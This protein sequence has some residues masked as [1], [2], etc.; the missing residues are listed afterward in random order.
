V[1]SAP[2]V[3]SALSTAGRGTGSCKSNGSVVGLS[4]GLTLGGTSA[5]GGLVTSYLHTGH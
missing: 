1:L 3:P 2:G 5:V 4:V